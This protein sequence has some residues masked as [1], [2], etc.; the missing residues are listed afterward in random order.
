MLL[1]LGPCA[2]HPSPDGA[3]PS[4][5]G[6]AVVGT[7][8][9]SGDAGVTDVTAAVLRGEIDGI[10]LLGDPVRRSSRRQW[11]RAV[12]LWRSASDAGAWVRPLVGGAAAA[13]DPRLAGLFG[14]FPGTEPFE[15]RR[16]GGVDLVL[17]DTSTEAD[18]QAAQVFWLPRA[19]GEAGPKVLLVPA[20]PRAEAVTGAALDYAPS[21]AGPLV[22]F[23]A[24]SESGCA[25]P[26]GAFAEARVTVG[27]LADGW[28]RLVLREGEPSLAYVALDDAPPNGTFAWRHGSEVGWRRTPA[29]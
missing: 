10:V 12:T 16:L 17:T 26:G 24:G 19:M 11:T 4:S 14:A 6:V 23:E 22:V 3:A 28:W 5:V 29:P 27:P 1:L 7:T 15:V 20:G 21:G 9:G 8:V 2:A 13:G 25:F 18:R